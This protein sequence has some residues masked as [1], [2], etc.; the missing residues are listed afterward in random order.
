MPVAQTCKPSKQKC[1]WL[2]HASEGRRMPGTEVRA[3]NTGTQAIKERRMP[4]TDAQAT[5][6]K[7]RLAQRP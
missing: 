7:Q 2:R 4:G 3:R 6:S 5:E 1:L